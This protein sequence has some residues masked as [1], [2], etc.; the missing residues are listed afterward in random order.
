[1]G[2][3]MESFTAYDKDDNVVFSQVFDEPIPLVNDWS[4]NSEPFQFSDNEQKFSYVIQGRKS[5][6]GIYKVAFNFKELPIMYKLRVFLGWNLSW[7]GN[8]LKNIG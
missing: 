3:R 6:W 5:N 2:I 1:M 4:E 8:K 7:F